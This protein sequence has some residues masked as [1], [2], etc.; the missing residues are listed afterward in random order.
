MIVSHPFVSLN[1]LLSL[2]GI[3]GL[4]ANRAKAIPNSVM[5]PIQ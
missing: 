1:G 5:Q 2:L 4:A 3:G